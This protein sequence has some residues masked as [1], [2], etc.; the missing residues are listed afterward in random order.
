[1]KGAVRS[2]DSN[3]HALGNASG[4]QRGN[5]N[6][7][8]VGGRQSPLRLSPAGGGYQ[9]VC[10]DFG[11]AVGVAG[12]ARAADDPRV[13]ELRDVGIPRVWISVAR[14]IGFDAFMQVWRVLMREEHVDERCR[15]VVPNLERYMR[16]QRN[17]LIRQLVAE[18][19]GV[20]EIREAVKGTTGEDVSES[21]IRRAAQRA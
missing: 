18:G 13:R 20:D 9:D 12:A 19:Y 1:M 15:I 21:H 14:E 17:R 8:Q 2:A 11:A 4:S 5:A 3:A 10:T 16:F 7:S 6:A